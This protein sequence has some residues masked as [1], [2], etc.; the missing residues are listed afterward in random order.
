MVGK[1]MRQLGAIL[2]GVHF[3]LTPAVAQ[4]KSNWRVEGK[5]LRSFEQ[6]K[7]CS[8]FKAVAWHALEEQRAR[9][10][11]AILIENLLKE[12]RAVLE[13]CGTDRG[14]VLNGEVTEDEDRTL[15]E[16][17]PGPYANWLAPGY[18]FHSMRNEMREYSDALE[19]IKVVLRF[20]CGEKEIR[21]ISWD[22]PADEKVE[23]DEVPSA[24]LLN[25]T[26]DSESLSG[27]SPKFSPLKA[28]AP[29]SAEGN[30]V[31]TEFEKAVE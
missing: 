22:L 7:D 28:Q 10:K 8:V 6:A 15:A 31:T 11:N 1:G 9:Q 17:C 14:M 20:R 12:R 30:A 18:R 26:R 23:S 27:V 5:N 2:L 16:M 24:E 4:G 29:Q 21:E 3:F 19:T 25:P 13:K